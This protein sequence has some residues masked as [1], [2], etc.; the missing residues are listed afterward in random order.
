[1]FLLRLPV[2]VVASLIATVTERTRNALRD[3]RVV[4]GLLAELAV[5]VLD[6]VFRASAAQSA[7][8]AQARERL[9][10]T[11]IHPLVAGAADPMV[12]LEGR[13]LSTRQFQ[14]G[15]HFKRCRFEGPGGIVLVGGTYEH[16]RFVDGTRFVPIEPGRL[17]PSFGVLQDCTV[18]HC[19]FHRVIIF[20]SQELADVLTPV[21]HRPEP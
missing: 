9:G 11:A 10:E 7:A 14:T 19:E 17:M 2:A 8:A 13:R 12:A 21:A 20:C 3:A 5:A 6:R 16:C 18:E 15:K 4:A 1:M